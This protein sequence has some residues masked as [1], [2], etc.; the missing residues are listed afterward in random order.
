M[1]RLFAILVSAAVLFSASG[2]FAGA[3][4]DTKFALHV[5]NTTKNQTTLCTTWSP[6]P[7]DTL[8]WGTNPPTACSNFVTKGASDAANPTFLV[9]LVAANADPVEGIGGIGCGIEYGSGLI[10]LS[11]TR[12]SDLEFSSGLWPASGGGNRI[13]WATQT[14]CQRLQVPSQSGNLQAVAGVFTVYL[15]GPDRFSVTTNNNVPT[16]ELSVANCNAAETFLADRLDQAGFVEFSVGATVDGC[17]P[18][19]T[20]C[21]TPVN[22]TTWGKIKSSYE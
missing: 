4:V 8:T 14:N 11:W 10:V 5:K 16:P 9:Y 6:V 22:K 19:V 18:C 21:G 1:N 13:T 12:C 3:M 7:P 2:A 15:Y 20:P 17:N